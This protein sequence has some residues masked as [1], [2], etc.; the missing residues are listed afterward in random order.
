[1]KIWKKNHDDLRSL[2]KTVVMVVIGWSFL[3]SLSGYFYVSTEKARTLELAKKEAITIFNKDK[4]FRMWATGHGG[5][6]VPITDDTPPNPAL[7]HMPER[8]IVTDQGTRLT[9]LNPSYMMRQIMEHYEELYGVEGHI[10]SLNLL[11]EDNL[12]AHS[13]GYVNLPAFGGI[14]VASI[15]FAP[16]G[17]KLAH[18]LP[19]KL[20]KRFF[21]I[22]LFILAMRMAYDLLTKAS[23]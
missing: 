11:N 19:D 18:I 20:L 8:D 3:C 14:V 15:L 6:Y 17:A 22:F 2:T 23:G 16:L 5:V 21:A 4:A 13:I 9:L 10:T 1:M 7:S 12:P